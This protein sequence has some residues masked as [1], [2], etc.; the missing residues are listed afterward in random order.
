LCCDVVK[1]PPVAIPF[2][3][4]GETEVIEYGYKVRID[5]TR[6]SLDG[7]YGKQSKNFLLW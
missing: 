5:G 3:Q 7:E 6:P 1:K 2:P 4:I